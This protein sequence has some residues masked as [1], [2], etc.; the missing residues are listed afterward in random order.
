MSEDQKPQQATDSSR[1]QPTEQSPQSKPRKPPEPTRDDVS[2][3]K[4]GG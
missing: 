1:A 2:W 4:K 3:V